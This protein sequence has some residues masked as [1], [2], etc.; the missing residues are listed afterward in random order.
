MSIRLDSAFNHLQVMQQKSD[1]SKKELNRVQ[2]HYNLMVRL[3]EALQA[4][5]KENTTLNWTEHPTYRPLLDSV[6]DAELLTSS[7]ERIYSF[8]DA[9]SINAFLSEIQIST[10]QRKEALEKSHELFSKEKENLMEWYRLLLEVI[11]NLS[12][13]VLTFAQRI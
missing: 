7:S 5:L 6:Y 9:S 11:S 8:E 3:N 12:Q 2:E 13:A 10:T 1:V 4:D